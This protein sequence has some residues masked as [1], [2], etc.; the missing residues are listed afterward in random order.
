MQKIVRCI[1]IIWVGLLVAYGIWLS[2]A[3]MVLG[4][5]GTLFESG[6]GPIWTV[7]IFGVP[8]GLFIIWGADT[9]DKP[10]P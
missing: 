2:L 7:I 9:S 6:L 1:S 3:S 8:G 4:I 5:D 10:Q